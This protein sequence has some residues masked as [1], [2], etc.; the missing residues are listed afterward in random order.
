MCKYNFEIRLS[1]G[2]CRHGSKSICRIVISH[3]IPH[4][5]S[6]SHILIVLLASM[7]STSIAPVTHKLEPANYLTNGEETEEFSSDDSSG[8]QLCRVNV[9]DLLE[10]VDWVCGAAALGEERLG[11]ADAFNKSLEVCLEG[12]DG[13][14]NPN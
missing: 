14:R 9:S 7:M 12:R 5:R 10:D 1:A 4:H 3:R 6:T 11:V 13:T 2:L 8:G